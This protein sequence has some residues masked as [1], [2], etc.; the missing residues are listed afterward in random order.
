[1]QDAQAE[2]ARWQPRLFPVAGM[3]ELFD[4]YEAEII[5]AKKSPRTRDSNY[6]ELKKLRQVFGQMEPDDIEVSHVYRYMDARGASS[7]TQA[8]HEL[9]LLKHIFKYGQRWAVCRHNPAAP[10]DKF[11]VEPRDRYISDEEFAAFLR[12]A[13]P[14]IR[15][16][17]LIKYKTGLRQKDLLD[18][19][20]DQLKSSGIELRTSKVRKRVIIPWDDELRQLV[21]EVLENNQR[22]GLQGETLFCNR[23]GKAYNKDGF[24]ARWQPSMRKALETGAIKERF[25]EHD[26]RTMHATDADEQGLDVQ[27]N[28]QHSD[29]RTTE[30]YLRGKR[31]TA[32]QGIS[33]KSFLGNDEP[34][35]SPLHSSSLATS[36]TSLKVPV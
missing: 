10:V 27:Q 34:P 29:A 4:R 18:L 5:P 16:Y 6:R 22:S 3:A 26:I 32:I 17:A 36:P 25:T 30:I 33:A 9:T 15:R 2:Y 14:W 24:H 11:R 31:V 28:L 1:M 23:K 35:P 13:S 12:V 19:R 21:D 20:L 7:R 8:N